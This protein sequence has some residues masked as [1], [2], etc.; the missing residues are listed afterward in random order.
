MYGTLNKKHWEPLY[1]ETDYKKAE[2]EYNELIAGIYK[3]RPIVYIQDKDQLVEDLACFWVDKDHVFLRVNWSSWN[4]V[5]TDDSDP[6]N[7]LC[8]CKYCF[9]GINQD[10]S[11]LKYLVAPVYHIEKLPEE[12]F[13]KV[14]Y[15]EKTGGTEVRVSG[16]RVYDFDDTDDSLFNSPEGLSAYEQ[17][18]DLYYNVLPELTKSFGDD[19]EITPKAKVRSD[20]ADLMFEKDDHVLFLDFLPKGDLKAL[21][22]SYRKLCR[23]RRSYK[24]DNPEKKIDIA[25]AAEE[26]ELK[27]L[28]VPLVNRE[29]GD[30]R[31]FPRNLLKKYLYSMFYQE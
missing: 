2:V 28:Y 1:P 10:D 14:S 4:T 24:K 19:V 9:V 7:R 20:E 16:H 5:S 3:S 18:I 12:L 6:I 27:E 13:E 26:S 22:E 21:L 30:L 8:E 29:M 23:M 31:V 11:N 25:F 17:N 15:D